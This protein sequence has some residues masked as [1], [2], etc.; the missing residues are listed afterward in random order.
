MFYRAKEA[1]T[2]RQPPKA[3]ISSNTG[4]VVYG[5]SKHDVGSGARGRRISEPLSVVWCS[6]LIELPSRRGMPVQAESL[7]L[8]L[9][10]K[11]TCRPSSVG[12]LGVLTVDNLGVLT[13]DNPVTLSGYELTDSGYLRVLT[14]YSHVGMSEYGERSQ[15]KPGIS[16]TRSEIGARNVKILSLADPD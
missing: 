14:S 4:D 8:T 11:G 13:V 9:K 2:S 1:K 5:L 6:L 15:L 10:H 12:N 3:P 16:E 7:L